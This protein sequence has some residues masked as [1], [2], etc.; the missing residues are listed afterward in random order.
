MQWLLTSSHSLPSPT[1]DTALL[2]RGLVRRVLPV[3]VLEHLGYTCCIVSGL[4]S[5]LSCTWSDEQLLIDLALECCGFEPHEGHACCLGAHDAFKAEGSRDV[6]IPVLDDWC[7]PQAQGQS[8]IGRV[9]VPEQARPNLV[10][11]WV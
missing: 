11:L 2:V 10:Y 8:S 4:V 3:F 5:L 9:Y 7:A 6:N 1:G